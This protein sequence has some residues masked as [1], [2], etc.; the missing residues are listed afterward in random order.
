MKPAGLAAA[1]ESLIDAV[2]RPVSEVLVRDLF[3]VI[4]VKSCTVD[5]GVFAFP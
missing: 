3:R 5:V 4:Q 1:A 2:S